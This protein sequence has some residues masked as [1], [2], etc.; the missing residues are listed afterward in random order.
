MSGMRLSLLLAAAALLL[1]PAAAPAQV[2]GSIDRL[3]PYES[4]TSATV[5]A[6]LTATVDQAGCPGC[7]VSAAVYSLPARRP[8]S[9]IASMTA[10]GSRGRA[11]VWSD[12]G[13]AP[14][15]LT[16]ENAILERE[17]GPHQRVCLVG[18]GDQVLAERVVDLSAFARL[19]RQKAMSWV[20]GLIR[21][22]GEKGCPK[23]R[24]LQIRCRR[25]SSSELRCFARWR[26]RNRL[27]GTERVTWLHDRFRVVAAMDERAGV[28][29]EGRTFNVGKGDGKP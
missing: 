21:C 14:L 20:R 5:Y 6:R 7:F 23:V 13:P 15:T 22:E 18:P 19:T 24:N 2:T 10:P 25:R 28:R 11:Y 12:A 3:E 1:P 17:D 8:C 26:A 16:R 29:A 4:A 9:S 27:T